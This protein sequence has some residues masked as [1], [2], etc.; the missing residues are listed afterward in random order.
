MLLFVSI[1][2]MLV[3]FMIGSSFVSLICNDYFTSNMGISTTEVFWFADAGIDYMIEEIRAYG[4]YSPYIPLDTTGYLGSGWGEWIYSPEL[5]SEDPLSGRFHVLAKLYAPDDWRGR[6]TVT[7]THA[8]LPTSA[9]YPLPY[10][11]TNAWPDINKFRPYLLSNGEP[12]RGTAPTGESYEPRL[13]RIV[14]LSTGFMMIGHQVPP[15][16]PNLD[17]KIMQ[18]KR[19]IAVYSLTTEELESWTELLH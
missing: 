5:L 3:L 9:T 14:I 7:G 16:V 15:A 11:A 1:F 2:L 18:R 12:I 17:Q 10:G 4:I 13:N 19:I 6:G 8:G